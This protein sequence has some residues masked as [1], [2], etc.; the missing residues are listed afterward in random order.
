MSEMTHEEA[1]NKAKREQLAR[2]D[3]Y[4]RLFET[5][6]GK[7]VLADL[8]RLYDTNPPLVEGDPYATHYA[9]GQQAVVKGIFVKLKMDTNVD[10]LDNLTQ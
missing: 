9:V 3:A 10:K 5:E 1:Q 4:K 6:D 7:I 8:V 2:I